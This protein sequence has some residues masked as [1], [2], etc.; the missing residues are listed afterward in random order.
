MGFSHIFF[1]LNQS[2]ENV[3]FIL[4]M[5]V[6]KEFGESRIRNLPVGESPNIWKESW[7]GLRAYDDT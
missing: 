3:Y 5:A 1:P 7:I 2:I 6:S 4:V